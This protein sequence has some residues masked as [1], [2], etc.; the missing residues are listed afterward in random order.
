MTGREPEAQEE[1][2]VRAARDEEQERRLEQQDRNRARGSGGDEQG[3]RGEASLLPDTAPPG[4]PLEHPSQTPLYHAY[5][6]ER[7]ARQEL[8]KAY[9]ESFDCRLVVMVDAI[10][11]DSVTYFEELL[12]D[13]D[14]ETD[15][16]LLVDSPGGDGDTAVRLVRSAQARCRELTVAVPNQAKSAATL[17]ALGGHRILMGPTSD[18]GPIDPQFPI[19]GRV[20]LVAAKDLIAAVEHADE[21]IAA[22][23]DSYP[24]YVSLLADVT[25]VMVQEARSSL[26][27][28]GELLRA[29]LASNP[30]RREDEVERIALELEEPLILVSKEHGEVFSAQDADEAGLPVIHAD[31]AGDQWRLL[32][33]LWAKYFALG[34]RVYEGYRASVVLGLEP[35]ESSEA[36][37]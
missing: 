7:Y 2:D 22:N 17:L 33:R 29:A 27:R 31:T 32:W 36:G 24:L 6:A 10:F 4:T 1:A 13:C 23:P 18:L 20:G 34:A 25:A 37:A 12:F 3:S 26:A 30:D 16:H 21:A 19:E 5:N 11:P 9:E 8:I 15:L 35:W 28:S 14:P